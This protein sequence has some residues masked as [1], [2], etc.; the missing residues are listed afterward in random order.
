MVFLLLTLNIFHTFSSVSVADFSR[1]FPSFESKPKSRRY[2]S[3]LLY[4]LIKIKSNCGEL[5]I[6]IFDYRLLRHLWYL[7]Y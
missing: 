6:S 5:K 4:S 2:W 7:N 1:A 3:I